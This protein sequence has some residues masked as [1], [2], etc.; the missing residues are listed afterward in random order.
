VNRHGLLQ[1][2]VTLMPLVDVARVR[3]R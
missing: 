3:V 2:S 1:L